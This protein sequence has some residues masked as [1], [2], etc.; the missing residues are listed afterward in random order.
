[1][2]EAP[3]SARIGDVERD[4]AERVVGNVADAADALQILVAEDRMRGLEPLL[5]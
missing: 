5:L 2:P 1:M 3:W 4:R